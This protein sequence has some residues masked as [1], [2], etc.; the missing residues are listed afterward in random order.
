MRARTYSAAVGPIPGSGIGCHPASTAVV[1][2]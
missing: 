2:G 1:V